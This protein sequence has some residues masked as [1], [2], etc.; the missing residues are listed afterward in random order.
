MGFQSPKLSH[1]SS[2]V[3]ATLNDSVVEP[4]NYLITTETTGNSTRQRWSIVNIDL[5]ISTICFPLTYNL[6]FELYFIIVF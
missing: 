1:C 4:Q 3:S 2:D 6:T 5:E